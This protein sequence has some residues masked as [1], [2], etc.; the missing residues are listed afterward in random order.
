M[1]F[2]ISEN[3][4]GA[5]VVQVEYDLIGS[6]SPVDRQYDSSDSSCST[7]QDKVFQAVLAK[8]PNAV[9]LPYAA[10]LKTACKAVNL[11][12]ILGKRQF[13][14]VIRFKPGQSVL[15][16]NCVPTN[17]IVKCHIIKSHVLPRLSKYY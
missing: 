6:K 5:T 10:F 16:A 17:Q 1:E 13:S 2:G 15:M 4:P 3:Y 8:D 12:L 14:I 11:L 9:I 7:I